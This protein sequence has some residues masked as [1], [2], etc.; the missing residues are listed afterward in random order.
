[1]V[2]EG[3]PATGVDDAD[4]FEALVASERIAGW[5]DALRAGAG[6]AAAD[7]AAEARRR[8]ALR[9][10]AAA[11]ATAAASSDA[12]AEEARAA[13][14]AG[15]LTRLL[16]APAAQADE[17]LVD[18][19]AAALAACAGV[20]AAPGGPRALEFRPAGGGAPVTV[21]IREGALGDGVGAKLWHAASILC[22]ELAACPGL[23][24]GADV[25]ELG[26]GVGA[27]GLLAARLGARSLALT[28]YVDA[29][30]LNL[31]AALRDNFPAAP[32]GAG[33][34]TAETAESW[35]A[36]GVGAPPG[37][38]RVR[39][40]NWA[41]AVAALDGGAD[42][43]GASGM[44]GPS[45]RGAAPELPPGERFSLVLASDV[46]YEPH[47]ARSVPA[48]LAHRLAPGGRALVC[49]A[50]RDAPLFAIFLEQLAARG[51][52]FAA[53]P[54]VPAPGEAGLGPGSTGAYEGGW[55]LVAAERAEAPAPAGGWPR[56]GLVPGG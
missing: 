17:A 13:G 46:V 33:A 34:E 5:V 52:R 16:K 12:Y 55:Q 45:T 54:V 9:G 8:A 40:L 4:F 15:A 1:M 26:A 36:V 28:D 3:A 25:L 31:R 20:G 41:D 19:V 14:A 23:V 27:A 10:A 49:C 51:L 7:G 35:D 21:A 37:G 53:E 18:A 6:T 32:G 30:L 43:G 50:V 24:A 39:F 56:A 42:G 22:R 11:L 38:A 29:L 47:M 44:D 48:V 2:A